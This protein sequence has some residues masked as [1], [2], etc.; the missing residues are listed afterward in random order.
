MTPPDATAAARTREIL[1]VSGALLAHDHFVYISGEHGPGWIDKDSVY[2][3]TDRT[4][5]LGR[6]LAEACRDLAADY[7][8]GPA[9]GGLVMAQ[10]TAHALGALA[11]FGE[12]PAP[13]DADGER[14]FVLK[15][16]Y[17]KRVPGRRVL[18]VDD[19]ANTGASLRGTVRAVREAGGEVVAAAAVCQRG[20]ATAEDLEAPEYRYLLDTPLE[21]WPRDDCPLCRDGVPVNTDFAHGRDFVDAGGDWPP[22][23]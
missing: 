18:V 15:R 11:V 6:F 5:E 4:E 23:P 2:P 22:R 12:H 10:W 13:H 1:E 3:Y 7:V 9:T 17:E 21:S 16:G 14:L 8:C 19:V 20:A